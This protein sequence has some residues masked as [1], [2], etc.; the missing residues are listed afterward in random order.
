LKLATDIVCEVCNVA[1][2][3]KNTLETESSFRGETTA[4]SE[5]VPVAM[6]AGEVAHDDVVMRGNYMLCNSFFA[7]HKVIKWFS[8]KNQL[9]T[10]RWRNGWFVRG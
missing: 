5:V 10:S 4:F 7:D 6:R 3:E 8:L 2:S 1:S 9:I